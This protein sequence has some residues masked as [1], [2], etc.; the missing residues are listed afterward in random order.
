V[1]WVKFNVY[2][3]FGVWIA[4]ITLIVNLLAK[5]QKYPCLSEHNEWY[6]FFT[7]KII[8]VYERSFRYAQ[9]H[10]IHLLDLFI[11]FFPNIMDYKIEQRL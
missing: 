9:L 10:I 4:Y 3:W 5:R 6:T 1:S 7:E 2:A 8:S 11:M